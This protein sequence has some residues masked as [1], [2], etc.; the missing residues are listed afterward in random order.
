MLKSEKLLKTIVGLGVVD[1]INGTIDAK[2]LMAKAE[3]ILESWE[4]AKS[5]SKNEMS[6]VERK[7]HSLN[8]HCQI[9]CVRAQFEKTDIKMSDIL[10]YFKLSDSVKKLANHNKILKGD[11]KADKAIKRAILKDIGY[12][13]SGK[14]EDVYN[15]LQILSKE[16]KIELQY[17]DFPFGFFDVEKKGGSD[18]DDLGL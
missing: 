6:E 12:T 5:R 11:S 2:Q 3:Q 13:Q 10:D 8:S 4:V 1:A 16:G 15:F 9:A 18:I 17:A 7:I 14:A